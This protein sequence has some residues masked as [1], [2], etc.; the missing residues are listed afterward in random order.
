MKSTVAGCLLLAAACTMFAGEHLPVTSIRRDFFVIPKS[1]DQM[2]ISP[3]IISRD[4]KKLG[5]FRLIHS[6]KRLALCRFFP[7]KNATLT[8]DCYTESY[9]R[10]GGAVPSQFSSALKPPENQSDR[11]AAAEPQTPKSPPST[12]T[13][14][15]LLFRKEQGFYITRDSI[16]FSRFGSIEALSDY[17][18][19]LKKKSPKGFSAQIPDE[20]FISEHQDFFTRI[21]GDRVLFCIVNQRPGYCRLQG[22]RPSCLP[23]TNETL[24][25]LPD[26]FH[27][28]IL[29][30]PAAGSI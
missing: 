19:A 25:S 7:E 17:I 14:S 2:I 28:Y 21:M 5:S 30:L 23:V 20:R 24:H 4:G 3:G 11:T 6:T 9:R 13:V 29:L 26:R 15:S 22:G 16:R 12:L 10:V 18:D 27:V 1:A 8:P